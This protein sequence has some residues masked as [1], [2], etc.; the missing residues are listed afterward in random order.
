MLT[1]KSILL[2]LFLLLLLI[3]PPN[4]F[5]SSLLN[6]LGEEEELLFKQKTLGAD[7]KLNQWFIIYFAAAS[8]IQLKEKFYNEICE[9]QNKQNSELSISTKLLRAIIVNGP[10][11]FTINGDESATI[12]LLFP[13]DKEE[14][15]SAMA[16][17]FFQYITA[18][19]AE[20]ATHNCLEKYIPEITYFADRLKF[21]ES[22]LDSKTLL[23]KE[24]LPRI[25]KIFSALKNINDIYKKCEAD[26]V[27][28]QKKRKKQKEAQADSDKNL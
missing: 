20:A 14:L 11:I 23:G 28:E 4:M 9:K 12:K 7:Y 18:V 16:R 24:E 8:K 13:I 10:L 25:E 5:A 2:S 6:C 15:N 26:F 19:Q 27:I 22:D 17:L 21:L 3:L 1:K